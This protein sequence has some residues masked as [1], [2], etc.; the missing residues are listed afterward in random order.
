MKKKESL[1]ERGVKRIPNGKI[2]LKKNEISEA[3]D[4]ALKNAR[5]E[6]VE[7]GTE[8]NV[9]KKIKDSELKV[10][11]NR[12]EELHVN[13]SVKGVNPVTVE[14]EKINVPQNDKTVK[15]EEVIPE[16]QTRKTLECNR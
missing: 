15:Q 7:L 10:L 1:S 9:N 6:R 13:Q 5:L 4:E 3:R 16:E 2:K 8:T 14:V 12:V 11:S